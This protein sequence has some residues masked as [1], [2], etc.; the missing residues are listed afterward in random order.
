MARTTGNYKRNICEVPYPEEPPLPEPSPKAENAPLVWRYCNWRWYPRMMKRRKL[1]SKAQVESSIFH[2]NF[3][4]LVPGGFNL[5]FI[6]TTC[7][8]LP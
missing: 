1:I 3:K 8:A 5:G 6:G 2:L 7:S 4:R